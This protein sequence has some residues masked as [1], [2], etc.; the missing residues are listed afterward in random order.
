MTGTPR[1]D[2]CGII[3]STSP[4][5]PELEMASSTSSRVIM[6]ISPWLASAACMKKDGVPVRG[7]RGCDFPCDVTGFAHAADDDPAMAVEADGAGARKTCVEARDQRL[8]GPALDLE[9]PASGGDQR[10]RIRL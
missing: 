10:G 9:R 5:S 3:S 8:D 2:R 4:V 7:Q 6:P 1:R